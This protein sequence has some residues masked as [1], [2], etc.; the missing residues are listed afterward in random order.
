M[1]ESGQRRV[2][3]GGLLLIF[4]FFMC[5]HSFSFF[6]GGVGGVI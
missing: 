3:V 2:G 1:N 6:G 4:I 5:G